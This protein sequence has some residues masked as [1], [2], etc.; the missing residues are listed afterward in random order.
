VRYW[1]LRAKD[2]VFDAEDLLDEMDYELSKSQVDVESQ[3]ATK[4]VWNSLKSSFVTFF[5]NEIESRMAGMMTKTLC[6]TGS[7]L[8]LITTFLYFL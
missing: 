5:E 3:S 2:V 6:L 8:T 4:K 7:H 1:L